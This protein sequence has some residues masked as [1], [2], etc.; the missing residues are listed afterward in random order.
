MNRVFVCLVAALILVTTS[1]SGDPRP[2]TFVYDVY[3]EGKENFEF[4]QY[5]TWSTHKGEEKGFDRFQ[6]KEEIEIGITD[7][8]DL[9]IY[10]ANWSYEDSAARKGASFDSVALQGIV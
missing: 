9:S 7:Y 8:F 6:T 10:V 3:S 1:A 4:E 2:W 5:L